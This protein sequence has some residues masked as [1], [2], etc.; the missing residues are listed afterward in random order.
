MNFNVYDEEPLSED[1]VI[2]EVLG[3]NPRA[4][5]LRLMRSALEMRL[6]G[7][8]R[9]L[10]KTK[11]SKEIK[12]LSS[13]I[14]ELKKQIEVIHKEEAITSFVEDSVRVTLVRGALEEEQ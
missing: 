14:V 6:A 9:E 1:D 11:D 13:K 12:T 7:F 4:R 10:G 8:T 5:E 2:D 3:E